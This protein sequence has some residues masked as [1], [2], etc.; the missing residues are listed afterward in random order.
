M[1]LWTC[2]IIA[3]FILTRSFP[4]R[5]GLL[6]C[7][8]QSTRRKWRRRRRRRRRW[9]LRI[10]WRRR[11]KPIRI[12][13]KPILFSRRRRRRRRRLK[14]TILFNE[15]QRRR[16]RRRRQ[17]RWPVCFLR[18]RPW[19]RRLV[20]LL[21][22]PADVI[23]IRTSL[24]HDVAGSQPIKPRVCPRELIASAERTNH[25]CTNSIGLVPLVTHPHP[26]RRH[27]VDNYW[28]HPWRFIPGL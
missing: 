20:V 22:E 21:S 25:K 10:L 5:R 2:M 3:D 23:F 26:L 13:L 15:Q 1:R 9:P 12:L 17:R 11:L 19:R 6:T 27:L 7:R 4:C 24:D 14:P 16:R 28:K 18:K 8:R